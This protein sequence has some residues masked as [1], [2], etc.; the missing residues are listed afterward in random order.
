MNQIRHNNLRT[1]RKSQKQFFR[2]QNVKKSLTI[3]KNHVCQRGSGKVAEGRFVFSSRVSY[4]YV[5]IRK[6]EGTISNRQT[7]P[8][9]RRTSTTN[10]RTPSSNWRTEIDSTGIQMAKLHH[11]KYT[12][13]GQLIGSFPAAPINNFKSTST[14][15]ELCLFQ[16]LLLIIMDRIPTSVHIE[17]D[18]KKSENGKVFMSF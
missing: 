8:R 18:E 10:R 14:C 3:H 11:W 5:T 2:Q 9:N 17:T 7:T 6:R 4:L 1:L 15:M 12:S 13:C 16:S